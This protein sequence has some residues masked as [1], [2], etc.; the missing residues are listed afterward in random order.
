M[1][2]CLVPIPRPPG[3][4]TS[5]DDRT[6]RVPRQGTGTPAIQTPKA[7]GATES[8]EHASASAVRIESLALQSRHPP[9]QY[10]QD[11]AS[12]AAR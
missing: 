8:G 12:L 5:F 3:T 2:R 6:V 1:D 11:L 9:T 10:W 4:G 7:E